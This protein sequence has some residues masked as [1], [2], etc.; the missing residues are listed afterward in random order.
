MSGVTYDR[1]GFQAML[2][3]IEA[4]R[5]AVC[6][7]KDLSRLGRNSALTGLYT[8]F[9]FPQYGVRYI[10]INDNFDTID[11]NSTDNDFAGIKNWCNEF[12]ARDTSRKIRAVN[13]AKGER[14]VP[15]TT[16]VPYGYLKGPDNPR[17]WKIDPVAAD[18]VRRI[19]SMCMEG[20]GPK[21]IAN[22]LKADK[23]LTPASYKALQGIKSPNKKPEDPYDWK[24]STVVAILERREYTGCTVNFKTY[25]NSIWDKKQRDNPIE[26]QAIFP[27]THERIIDDDVFEKVQ[28]IRQQR[29]RMI[30]T[31]RSSIFSGLVY[32]A[33]CGSKML[34]G[35]SNNGDLDQDFLTALCT[36]KA[37]K[38]V[39]GISFASKSWIGWFSS[40]FRQL[41]GIS[42]DTRIISAR[43]WRN[44]SAWKAM[45]KSASAE[46]V[47]KATNAVLPS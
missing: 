13:K 7:T 11:P 36:A 8:N 27:N 3:E 6:I 21:Q 9:T 15:L 38:S 20:R 42:C 40:T 47:W 43:S 30:R 28:E 34:Y 33:D 16:N 4:E 26:K 5:V 18:V 23:V 39:M 35:S 31:G 19:F 1:P 45:S 32:C 41:W 17:R 24:S 29:H 10:A 12:Y 2:A 46:S 25:T 14:G 22:Q 37:K 44:S